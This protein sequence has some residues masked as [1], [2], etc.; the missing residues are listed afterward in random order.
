[1]RISDWSSDVC[2]SDLIQ[3]VYFHK[4][5]PFA[6]ASVEGV[7]TATG[8]NSIGVV[9]N[10][11]AGGVFPLVVGPGKVESTAAKNGISMSCTTVVVPKPPVPNAAAAARIKPTSNMTS[12]GSTT[13]LVV[14]IGRAHD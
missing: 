10:T 13:V 4:D 14:A 7:Y 6:G 3:Q 11:D 2:S 8:Q 1:M 9:G 12:T 5:D